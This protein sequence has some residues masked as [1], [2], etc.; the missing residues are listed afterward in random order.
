M[1]TRIVLVLGC[2]WLLAAP[3]A[4]SIPGGTLDDGSA[5]T[6]AAPTPQDTAAYNDALALMKQG[7]ELGAGDGA[8]DAYSSA[9]AKLQALTA[10]SPQF[11]E[12]W[13]SL[14]YTQRKLV[15]MTMRW[16]PT[17]ERWI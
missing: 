5:E 10:R 12:A 4:W 1:R 7:D 13:N 9:R 15:R 11:A 14:G 2:V 16:P 6:G 17:P 8:H 3:L